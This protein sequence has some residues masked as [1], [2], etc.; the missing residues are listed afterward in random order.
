M[1]TTS[2]FAV[3]P[4]A[5]TPV[6]RAESLLHRIAHAFVAVQE[7]RAQRIVLPYLARCTPSEL[8]DLGFGPTEIAE[9]K[10]HRHEPVVRWV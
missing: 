10:R 1:S 8:S 2:T 9:I 4:A 5:A 7:A 6:A 3:A